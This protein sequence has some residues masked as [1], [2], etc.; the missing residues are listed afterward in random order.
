VSFVAETETGSY[1]PK[2]FEVAL[3]KFFK[4][5]QSKR[6]STEWKMIKSYAV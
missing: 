4:D 3:R 5:V 1:Q 6:T 2:F